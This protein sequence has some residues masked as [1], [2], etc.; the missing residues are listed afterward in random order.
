MQ[1]LTNPKALQ[2]MQTFNWST[3]QISNL[4]D[5]IQSEFNNEFVLSSYRSSQEDESRL[6]ITTWKL[7]KD[8]GEDLIDQFF[9]N[10]GFKRDNQFCNCDH[11]IFYDDHLL[12]L[13]IHFNDSTITCIL[14]YTG[15]W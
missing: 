4:H 9:S 11:L 10:H 14:H 6:D 12:S 8:D 7:P 3:D 5:S 13:E 15:Q 1:I 2:T